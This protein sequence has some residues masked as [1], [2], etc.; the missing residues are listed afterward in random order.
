MEYKAAKDKGEL[1]FFP[2]MI[3]LKRKAHID[4]IFEALRVVYISFLRS[5]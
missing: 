4:V 1:S 5:I 3:L 2:L